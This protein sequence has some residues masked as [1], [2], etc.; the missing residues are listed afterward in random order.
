MLWFRYLSARRHLQERPW[1][2][3]AWP[4]SSWPHT[5]VTAFSSFSSVSSVSSFP[6]VKLSLRGGSV[7]Y[8][9]G[10]RLVHFVAVRWHVLPR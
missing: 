6:T 5:A 7:H 9:T 4:L 10:M 3:S 2:V 8:D 1:A